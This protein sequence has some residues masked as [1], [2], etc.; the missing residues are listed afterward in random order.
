MCI[1]DRYKITT[2]K[3]LSPQG[4]WVNDTE[5]IEPDVNISLNSDYLKNPIDA[6]DNQLKKAIEISSNDA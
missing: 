3:W 4:I 2:K 1:R 5:G 6:N